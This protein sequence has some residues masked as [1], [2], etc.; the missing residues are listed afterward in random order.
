MKRSF[1]LKNYFAKDRHSKAQERQTR[2]AELWGAIMAYREERIQFSTLLMFCQAFDRTVTVDSL[3][4][5]LGR[6]YHG[7]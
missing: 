5:F 2:R 4:N 6:S 7:E 3:I 1:D